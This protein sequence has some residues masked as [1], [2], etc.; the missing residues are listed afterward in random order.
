ML[1]I[2]VGLSFGSG[3]HP[4]LQ[5]TACCQRNSSLTPGLRSSSAFIARIS[6]GNIRLSSLFDAEVR[7]IDGRVWKS[8]MR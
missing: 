6:F 5:A 1:R 4:Q 8:F 3:S 7:A 2:H